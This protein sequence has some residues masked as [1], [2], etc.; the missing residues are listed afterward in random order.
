[1]RDVSY[2]YKASNKVTDMY[3]PIFRT[4]ES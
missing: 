4:L 2:P 3:T 1:V